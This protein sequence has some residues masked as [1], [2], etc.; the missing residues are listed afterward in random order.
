MYK[1]QV[2]KDAASGAIYGARAAGGVILVTTKR[3]K[4]ETTFQ[5][6]YNNNFA[7]A[8][9]MNL[10]E[11]APLMEYLQA[12]SDA[13]GD[14]FWTMGSPSVSKWMGYLEQYRNNPSSIPTVGDGIFKDADGAVYYMNE[15]D[16]TKNMLETSFQQ[17][18]NISMTGGTEKLR[19]RL[20][21]GYI[22]NNGV[23]ITDKDQYRRM[24]VSGFISANITKWFTQEATL[25]YAHSK[26]TLPSSALG[27]IY[28]TRLASFYPEGNMPAGISDEAEGLPFFTP[29]NQIRW[30]NPSKTLNDNPR[31]FLKSILKP[32]KGLEVAFE[33][34]FDK[35]IYDYHWYTGSVA[36]TTVQGGKDTT[37]TNDYLQKTKRY[38]DYNSCL[39]YTSPSPRD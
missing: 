18:H 7:F 37:P 39:L 33:Y 28:S 16:L 4:G 36:Y 10:P 2:L 31:I 25:S 24:N 22:D 23:L 32:L 30:S 1:R 12:Y 6:N 27:A 17:S 19:F 13:A 3:P 8:S 14:Q 34:T 38:T 9:A 20:S 5:L 21:A 11:Q 15:K 35:K 29:A 26:K